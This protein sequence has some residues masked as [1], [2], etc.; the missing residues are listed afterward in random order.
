MIRALL[1][2]A[3]ALAAVAFVAAA[4]R[5][6]GWLAVAVMVAALLQPPVTMLSRYVPRALAVPVVLLVA[7]A[8]VGGLAFGVVGDVDD[9]LTRLERAAPRA[10]REIEESDR[11]G[12]FA[13]EVDLAQRVDDFV[14]DLPERLRGGDEVTAIR[15]AATRGVAFF[16]TLVLTIFLMFSGPGLVAAGFEQIPDPGR[17]ERVRSLVVSAHARWWRYLVLTL[18]R[19]VAAGLFAYAV[20]L[21]IDVPGPVL[22]AL[23][24]GVWSIVPTIGVLVGAIAVALLA[25]PDSFGTVGAVL[26]FF[27][28]YQVAEDVLVQPRLERRSL[29][30][31]AFVTFVAA[32]LGLEVYGIGGLIGAVVLVVFAA[33]I[34]K[35]IGLDEDAGLFDAAQD[36]VGDDGPTYGADSPV[37][38]PVEQEG[39]T[40]EDLHPQG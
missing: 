4:S 18:I 29:H 13:T 21:I 3:A 2:I 22:L 37:T 10:A 26:A 28:A 16:A 35:E 19:M 34:V 6:L 15:S 12:E 25:A 39:T 23:W 9:Q 24:V 7:L 31:G 32:G 1:I 8:L 33:A 14:D 36:V 11:F 20:A 27:V 30:V 5:P 38:Q 40:R 17:R